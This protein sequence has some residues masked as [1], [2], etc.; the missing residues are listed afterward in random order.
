MPIKET[1]QKI[2][3][4]KK[5]IK[6]FLA[7]LLIV[8]VIIVVKTGV[9]KKINFKTKTANLPQ[10]NLTLSEL[11]ENDSD[12]DGIADWEE[13]LWGTDPE[14]YDTDDD[15]VSDGEEIRSEKVK[16]GALANTNPNTTDIFARDLLVTISSLY[17]TNIINIDILAQEVVNNI[18][19][20]KEPFYTTQNITITNNVESY[21]NNFLYILSLDITGWE[22]FVDFIKYSNGDTNIELMNIEEK[23]TEI[24]EISKEV[25]NTP[26]I[27][28]MKEHHLELANSIYFLGE[29]LTKMSKIESDPIQSIEGY[30]SYLKYYDILNQTILIYNNEIEEL[31]N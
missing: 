16:R 8:A 10:G 3:P 31:I 19:K 9:Y 30:Y 29:S 6:M 20:N 12:K 4:S 18:T 2:K 23:G 14:K 22:E 5:I 27:S 15:G 21:F 1:W 25:I 13:I 11:G 28:E 7:V 24:I 17:D 26:V